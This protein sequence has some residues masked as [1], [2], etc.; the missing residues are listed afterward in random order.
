[1]T[2]AAVTSNNV[3]T[4]T[5]ALLT[6][7]GVTWRR[8]VRSRMVWVAAVIALFPVGLGG[9]SRSSD[10]VIASATL[11][12]CILCPALVAGAVAEEIE[13]RTSTYL[14]SRPLPR[15]TLLVG[16]LLALAPIATAVVL[17]SLF[18][19][20]QAAGGAAPASRMTLAF[21]AGSLAMSAMS[22]GLGT[23]LPRHGMALSIAYF[24][25]I[26]LP[27]GAIPASV[28]SISI[29]RQV[30]LIYE[31]GPLAEPLITMAVLSALL[32]ALGLWRLRR[33]EA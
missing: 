18:V 21:A 24:I 29:T 6:L 8:F 19:A 30:R 16:K 25:L 5:A 4:A 14:W 12:M 31:P 26:D 7:F 10:P 20:S 28:R 13:D 33:L 3:P 1:V 32:L 22:A 27:V 17:A 9:A 23:L 15:W 2:E 11:V